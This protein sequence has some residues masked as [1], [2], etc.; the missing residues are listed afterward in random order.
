MMN[1]EEDLD[2]TKQ[3]LSA[4]LWIRGHSTSDSLLAKLVDDCDYDISFTMDWHL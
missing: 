3:A 4:Y 2:V 1:S